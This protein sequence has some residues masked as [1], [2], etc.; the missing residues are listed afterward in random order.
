MQLPAYIL[1]IPGLWRGSANRSDGVIS[2]FLTPWNKGAGG[3]IALKETQFPS[4][5][6]FL[7]YFQLC[8]IYHD[9]SKAETFSGSYD[10][11]LLHSVN[12]G[13]RGRN[14]RRSGMKE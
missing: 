12:H 2:I 14:R 1:F 13:E 4:S 8:V 9:E 10:T 3:R 7:F 6:Y 11:W 5:H